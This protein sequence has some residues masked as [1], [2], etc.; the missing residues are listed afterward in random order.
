LKLA[1]AFGHCR[2]GP[3]V[4]N[5][6]QIATLRTS[7]ECLPH[8]KCCPAAWIDTLLVSDRFHPFHFTAIGAESPSCVFNEPEYGHLTRTFG[9]RLAAFVSDVSPVSARAHDKKLSAGLI[10]VIYLL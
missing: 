4:V 3:V 2:V 1:E 10:R 7:C 6:E 9:P 5:I 8:I